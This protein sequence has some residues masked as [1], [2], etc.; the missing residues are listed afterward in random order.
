MTNL[1]RSFFWAASY[2]GVIFILGQADYMGRPIINFASYFYLAVIVATPLTL[3]FP[4]VSRVSVYVP[5]SVWAGV[6]MILLQILDRRRSTENIEFSVIVLEFVLLEI[7]VWLAYQLAMQISH[8]ESLM[9]AL[10]LSAFP[11]RTHTIEAEEQRIKVEITR[12][13]RYHRPLSLVIMESETEGEKSTRA[14]LKSI[15]HDLSSRFASARVG[16]IIDDRIRQTD[17]L[18]RDHKGRFIIV[19]PETDL[20]NATLLA[21]RISQSVKEKIDLDV[22]WGVA[23]FPEDALTFE[24]L[25]HMAR[26]RLIRFTPLPDESVT[27]YH[28]N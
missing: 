15:Q 2:I 27:A 17:L 1:K 16:Q 22:Y 6:Y 7:G 28:P 8:A 25:L 23:A 4:Y 24:D 14:M 10:A 3:F 19:C 9:D 18:L 21:K 11:N 5:M 20:S 26:E 13:R 12:S